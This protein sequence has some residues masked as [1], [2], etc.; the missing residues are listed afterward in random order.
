[1]DPECGRPDWTLIAQGRDMVGQILI[2][3][4]LE[5]LNLES[6]KFISSLVGP[7]SL[8]HG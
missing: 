7:S 1:M 4:Y 2:L 5:P 6:I 3:E 8:Q